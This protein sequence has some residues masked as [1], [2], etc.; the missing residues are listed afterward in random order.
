[1]KDDKL[2]GKVSYRSP[3][4]GGDQK[5][6]TILEFAIVG[7]VFFL[8]TAGLADI[9]RAVWAYHSLSYAVREGARY[10]IV[11]G[12]RSNNPAPANTI[13]N[14]VKNQIPHFQGVIVT[15][16]WD[17]NNAQASTVEVT[18]QY[19]FQPVMAFFAFTVPLTATTRMAISY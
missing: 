10:A 16:T 5:G 4:D 13:E 7:L 19:T 3:L 14:I 18:A 9:G 6:T 15:A 11:H 12:D 2:S 8:L 17:P 1:M